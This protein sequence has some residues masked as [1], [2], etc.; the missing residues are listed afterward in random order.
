MAVFAGRV[1]FVYVA[2]KATEGG[3]FVM[4][5]IFVAAAIATIVSA[6]IVLIQELRV[7]RRK[8]KQNKQKRKR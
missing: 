6:L 1:H 5:A 4:D 3:E 8:M 2:S 7:I